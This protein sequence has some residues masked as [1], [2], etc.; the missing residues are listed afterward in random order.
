[1]SNVTIG[2][3]IGIH[4]NSVSNYIKIYTVEGFEGLCKTNY[5]P[6]K[7][8]LEAYSLSIIDD[9]TRNPICSINQA[10]S[11]IKELTGIERKPTQIKAFLHRHGFVYLKMAAIPG[12]V[13]PPQAKTMA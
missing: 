1:M 13:D 2:A 7:S 6:Q 10:I 12:K 8:R 9:F 11:R 4:P 3:I 5:Q